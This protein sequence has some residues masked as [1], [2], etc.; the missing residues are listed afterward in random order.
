M[1]GSRGHE[2]VEDL[3]SEQGAETELVPQTAAGRA[4]LEQH[5]MGHDWDA[6]AAAAIA[7]QDQNQA[8]LGAELES[9]KARHRRLAMAAHQACDNILE[10]FSALAQDEHS[11]PRPR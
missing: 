6:V 7:A 11:E 1:G 10:L 2:A 4:A 5:R 9:I 8:A 3:V